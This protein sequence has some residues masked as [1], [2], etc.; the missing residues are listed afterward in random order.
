MNLIC[1]LLKPKGFG[2]VLCVAF[3]ALYVPKSSGTEVNGAGVTCEALFATAPIDSKLKQFK[4]FSLALAESIVDSL[5]QH[6]APK[7]PTLSR[8]ELRRRLDLT[9]SVCAGACY[10][11]AKELERAGFGLRLQSV[12]T[13]TRID[14]I[15]AQHI[16]LVDRGFFGSAKLLIVDPTIRQFF[17]K[18]L[19]ATDLDRNIPPVFVGTERHLRELFET[20]DTTPPG[21]S[22]LTA[23]D[24]IQRYLD[25]APV[26]YRLE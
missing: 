8:V 20:H 17:A 14:S 7:Y 4:H 18:I 11:L 26:S 6:E 2:L 12:I 13:K 16:Y 9:Q 23:K 5:I 24:I 1:V 21:V 3:I 10:Y 15:G 22:V 19:S 25:T